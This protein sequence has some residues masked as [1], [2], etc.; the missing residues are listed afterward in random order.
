MYL[1]FLLKLVMNICKE[2][3]KVCLQPYGWSTVRGSTQDV[4]SPHCLL[5]VK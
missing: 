4:G 3:K 2:N 1:Y 5:L